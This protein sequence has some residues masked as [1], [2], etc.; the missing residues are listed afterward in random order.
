[1]DTNVWV[2]SVMKP[3]RP[4]KGRLVEEESTDYQLSFLG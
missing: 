2:A 4:V 1:M 3:S